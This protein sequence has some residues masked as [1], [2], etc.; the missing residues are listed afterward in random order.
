MQARIMKFFLALAL[1][2]TLAPSTALA[3]GHGHGGGFGG[4]GNRDRDHDHD[5][6]KD[7]DHHHAKDRD[8][9]RD[10]DRDAD[11]DRDRDRDHDRDA[12]NTPPGWK[13]GKKKGWGDCDV[14]PGQ[15]KKMGCDGDHDRDDRVA[16]RH[17][18]RDH[19]RD[20]RDRDRDHDRDAHNTTVGPIKP[21]PRP[22]AKQPVTTARNTV[23]VRTT[24]RT[25]RRGAIKPLAK[26]STTTGAAPLQQQ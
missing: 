18:D 14:P 4:F 26:K 22:L 24:T 10:H 2:F 20:S 5:S 12:R 17:H 21:A 23:P 8:K 25:V 16:H 1:A 11:H 6:D 13:H 9:D 3:A 19:D 15:A 7:R